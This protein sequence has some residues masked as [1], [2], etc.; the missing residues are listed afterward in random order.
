[1]PTNQIRVTCA[2]VA[3]IEVFT[4]LVLP[5]MPTNQIRVLPVHALPARKFARVTG[6]K[7][8]NFTTLKIEFYHV[9]NWFSPPWNWFLTFWKLILTTMELIFNTLEIDIYH[10]R[11]WFLTPWILLFTT[12]EIDFYHHRNGCFSL[13]NFYYHKEYI[14]CPIVGKYYLWIKRWVLPNLN[15]LPY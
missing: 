4:K 14:N 10:R 5:R 13:W 2:R 15:S 7:K 9:G 8:L 1:M 6:G 3:G 12:V 11:N